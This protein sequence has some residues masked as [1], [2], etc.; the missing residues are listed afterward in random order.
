MEETEREATRTKQVIHEAVPKRL[1]KG[2]SMESLAQVQVD[3]QPWYDKSKIRDGISR[4][5]IANIHAARQVFEGGHAVDAAK[6]A[7]QHP[8]IQQPHQQQQQR[9]LP[10]DSSD[11]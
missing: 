11:F 2:K 5:S 10:P 8:G 1:S 9:R 7:Q 4:E 6:W 3:Y